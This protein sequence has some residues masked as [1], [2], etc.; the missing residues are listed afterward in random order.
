LKAGMS[1][2]QIFALTYIDPWF[3]DQLVEILE[4]EDRLRSIPDLQSVDTPT[5][6]RA[7][8]FGFSDRQLATIWHCGEMD[9]REERKRR[10]VAVTF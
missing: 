1:P 9:V 7:K 10:G 4:M 3:L 6:R 5:L 8:Q 2:E